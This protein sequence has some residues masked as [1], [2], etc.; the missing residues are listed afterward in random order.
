MT[1]RLLLSVSAVALTAALATSPSHASSRGIRVDETIVCTAAASLPLDLGTGNSAD[2]GLGGSALSVWSCGDSNATD[3]VA[4][5]YSFNTSTSV[6][7]TW[8]PTSDPSP[9]GQQLSTYFGADN[10]D[11]VAMLDVFNLTGPDLGDTEVQLDYNQ[12]TGTACPASSASLTWAGKTYTFN[13][14]CN[15]P[16]L[17]FNK[18]GNQISSPVPEPDTLMLMGLAALPML[19]FWSRRRKR[20]H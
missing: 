11:I 1:V 4:G 20:V 6:L 15:A 10:T 14:P 3:F 5:G 2:V 17:Y 19:L 18:S 13:S 9:V 7:Y 16:I 12:P 8:T